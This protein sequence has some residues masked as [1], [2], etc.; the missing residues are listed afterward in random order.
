MGDA[1][2][3][4]ETIDNPAISYIDKL[5]RWRMAFFGMVIL[6]AGVVIGGASMMILAPDR[7]M[8][9]PRGPEFGS[10]RMIPPLR[11][12]L[13]LS[14]EQQEKIKPILDTH[15]EKLDEIR[16]EARSEIE[17]AL[18]LMNESISDILT[19]E[20]RQIWQ[21][22]LDRLDR[23]FHRG[24]QYRGGGPRGPGFRGSRQEG[25]RGGQPEHFPQGP[26]SFG[27]HRPPR[28]PNS[29]RDGMWR[30]TTDN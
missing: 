9:P 14:P 1:M 5:H 15:M 26:G 24:G 4:K 28:G 20:Q 27:P 10:Q 23:E 8:K 16:V 2:S 6:V 13:G 11:R 19:E 25:F 18:T 30:D 21:R 12:E 17:E 7:L 29:P 3:N 22:S